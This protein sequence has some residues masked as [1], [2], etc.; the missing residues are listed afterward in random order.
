MK[1]QKK[2]YKKKPND[3]VQNTKIEEKDREWEAKI[4]RTVVRKGERKKMVRK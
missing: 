2:T 4:S 1:K 3:V